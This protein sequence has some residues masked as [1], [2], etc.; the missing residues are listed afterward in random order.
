LEINPNYGLAYANIAGILFYFKNESI[1]GIKNYLKAIELERGPFLPVF[2]QGLG[3]WYEYLGFN[4]NAIDIYNQI[5]QLTKDTLQ[6]FQNMSG[7]YYAD[8]NWDESIRWAKKILEKD[9]KNLFANSQLADIYSFLGKDD[10]SNYHAEKVVEF[11]FWPAVV[12][13]YKG[14]ILWK[15]GDK[16]QAR[17]TFDKLI[18]MGT[19]LIKS[20][21]NADNN[22]YMLASIFSLMGEQEKAMEYFNKVSLI[23]LRQRWFINLMENDPLFQNIRSNERFQE[24]LI[25]S[26]SDY[27]KEHEKVRIW[28]EENN[29]LKI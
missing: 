16:L 17:T 11:S 25:I 23:W 4:E 15:R 2:L 18:E 3:N 24:I 8:E 10:S 5:F 6:Y 12:A 22:S 1:D 21:I 29:L 13:Y 9:P 14:I 7:P 20:D 27:Q 26:K 19:N 28:L